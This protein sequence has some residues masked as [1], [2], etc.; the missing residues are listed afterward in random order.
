MSA[1]AA[2][3]TGGVILVL[4]VIYRAALPRPIPGIPHN[5]DAASKI[6]GDIPEMMGHVKRTKRIFV[7][8]VPRRNEIVNTL[9]GPGNK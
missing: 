3:I 5:K 4:F 8:L 6:L 7:C 9:T 1:G 2:A